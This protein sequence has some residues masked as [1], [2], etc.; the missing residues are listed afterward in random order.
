MSRK[1]H[2]GFTLIELLVVIAIIGLLASVVLASLDTVRTK[3]KAARLISDLQQIE[4]A[5]I[6]WGS[7]SG[8]NAWWH[9][10]TWG[11]PLDEPTI[12]WL[13]ANTDLGNWLS[14]DLLFE[15]TPYVYDNDSDT[16]DDDND[17]C[18]ALWRGPYVLVRGSFL[19]IAQ[20]MD[21]QVDGGDGSV[22][23]RIVW[24]TGGIGYLIGNNSADIGF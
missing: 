13:I 7:E 20:E 10:D 18:G 17:G 16:F 8:I 12:T 11:G 2:K 14:G 19:T 6:V 21:K 1:A 22:C 5:L 24:N 9:E 3:A 15:G 4:R 23:G